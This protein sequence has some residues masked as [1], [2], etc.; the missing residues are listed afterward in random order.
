MNASQ[1]ITKAPARLC[2]LQHYSQQ[3]SY[4]NVVSIHNGI[5]LSHEE[6]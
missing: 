5:L 3:P 2:L 4:R 6:K 1:I